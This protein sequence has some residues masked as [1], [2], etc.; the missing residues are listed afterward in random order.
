MT[1]KFLVACAAA[2]L[3]YSGVTASAA[4]EDVPSLV[5]RLQKDKPVFAKRQQD[6]L[7]ER[8][9]LTDHPTL[10]AQFITN[11]RFQLT[12]NLQILERSVVEISRPVISKQCSVVVKC[13]NGRVAA[14]ISVN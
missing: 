11:W 12:A 3:M 13:N 7:T 9:D 5:N 10:K 4:E 8:Y 1:P 6:L 14:R 2:L